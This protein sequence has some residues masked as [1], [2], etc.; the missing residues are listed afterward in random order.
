MT[1]IFYFLISNVVRSDCKLWSNCPLVCFTEGEGKVE[2]GMTSFT[3][4]KGS[5]FIYVELVW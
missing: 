3:S 4:I 5:I 2:G 1:W